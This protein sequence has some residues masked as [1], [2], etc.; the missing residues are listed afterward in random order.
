MPHRP[1]APFAGDVGAAWEDHAAEWVAWARAPGHDSYWHFHRDAFLGL[2]PAP[3]RLTLDIGCGEGRLAADLAG[4]AHRV[5][6][7]DVSPTLI[8]A[9][10]EA[11]P[12]VDF[13]LA[14]AAALPVDDAAADLAVAFM[15]LHDMHDAA[16]ALREV[17]RVLEPGGRFCIAIVHPLNSAGVW[18]AEHDADS[19]FVIAGSYLEQRNSVDAIERDGLT[20]TFASTHRPLEA[21][22]ELLADAGFVIE[23]LRERTYPG[24]RAFRRVVA[25]VAARPAVPAPA[26]SAHPAQPGRYARYWATK[27]KPTSRQNASWSRRVTG[28]GMVPA[29]I[30]RP[31]IEAIGQT[32]RLVE[33]TNASS[34]V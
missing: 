16:G 26:R 17:A 28:P 31:L 19:P 27:S 10:R 32:H 4:L 14:D 8:E 11:H 30:G 12:T 23:R 13:R 24:R 2:V 29:C 15:S 21:Y 1:N 7:I 6:G 20:M 18:S 34:A 25:E 3:G 9:A 33:V 5:V 22:T